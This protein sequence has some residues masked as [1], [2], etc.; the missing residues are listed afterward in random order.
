MWD[1]Q[2]KGTWSDR[3]LIKSFLLTIILPAVL[4][5]L[6][7][8]ISSST[9]TEKRQLAQRPELPDSIE[10][11]RSYPQRFSLFFDDHFPLR[12]QLIQGY[13][14]LRVKIMKHSDQRHVLMG[15][16]G[17]LFYTREKLL[18]DFSGRVPFS[19]E[20]LAAFRGLVEAR[21][22]WLAARGIAYLF[23]IPPNKQ[24]IYPEYMPE[25]YTRVKGRTRMD[26]LMDHMRA[27]SD[28]TV[29]DLRGSLLA[30][31]SRHQLYY[32]HDSHWNAIGALIGYGEI[33]QA[34]KH[35][36]PQEDRSF[37]TLQDFTLSYRK[38]QGGDLTDMLE[39]SAYFSEEAPLLRPAGQFKSCARELKLE[40]Y[41]GRDWKP[42]KDPFAMECPRANLTMVMFRDSFAEGLV[43][44][45]AEH[46]RRSVYIS[47]WNYDAEIF[48]AVVA[49]E[50]PH[51]VI[52]ECGE[53]LLYYL[54]TGPDHRPGP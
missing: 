32:R 37:R 49:H 22:D 19:E 40:D 34:V 38:R 23:V 3:L 20:K 42:F 26:Q 14:Y 15:R 11:L 4:V 41:L 52:D 46:F 47:K 18:Q 12:T 51:I 39:L 27:H 25:N 50:Q 13:N 1:P 54:E 30:A 10:T 43:G 2:H 29:V 45:L 5:I 21:R 48:K 33:M 31:K 35:A 9:R 24:T 8:Q 17:W 44:Y 7:W 6:P 53:R 28:V 16:N 36:F